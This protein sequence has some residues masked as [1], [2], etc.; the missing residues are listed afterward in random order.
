MPVEN[1]LWSVYFLGTTNEIQEFIKSK[2]KDKEFNIELLHSLEGLVLGPVFL[3]A[4]PPLGV[5]F[6]SNALYKSLSATYHYE[7]KKDDYRVRPGL[8][9]RLRD[10]FKNY[11]PVRN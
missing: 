11:N 5:Y 9:G 7:I 1:N 6:E 2:G 4:F 3:F 8:I 10:I